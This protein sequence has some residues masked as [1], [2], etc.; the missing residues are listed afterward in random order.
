MML[1]LPGPL[2]QEKNQKSL[3]HYRTFGAGRSD[4]Q[5]ELEGSLTTETVFV[6]KTLF[7]GGENIPPNKECFTVETLCLVVTDTPGWEVPHF[8]EHIGLKI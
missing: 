3:C 7:E 8:A 4:W 2:L 1:Q 5:R 6:L